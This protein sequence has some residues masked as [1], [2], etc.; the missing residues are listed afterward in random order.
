[1][2]WR[3]GRSLWSGRTL[4]RRDWVG[5]GVI[6]PIDGDS[7]T[8]FGNGSAFGGRGGGFTSSLSTFVIISSSTP[9][10]LPPRLGRSW[11]RAERPRSSGRRTGQHFSVRSEALENKLNKSG[12]KH[13]WNGTATEREQTGRNHWRERRGEASCRKTKIGI[14]PPTLSPS[15]FRR[16]KHLRNNS[17]HRSK[18]GEDLSDSSS[19][20][21]VNLHGKR[22]ID[23]GKKV[24][25]FPLR[26]SDPTKVRIHPAR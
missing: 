8:L 14:S 11:E 23:P 26:T 16:Q 3:S 12:G 2:A 5:F 13:L 18:R 7:H 19:D 17:G 22:S 4:W 15:L 20:D 24:I 21:G 9:S 6:N 10:F 1:M 25:L